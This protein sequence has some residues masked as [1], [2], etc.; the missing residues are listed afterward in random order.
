MTGPALWGR[1]LEAAAFP[2][3]VCT[4]LSLVA[5]TLAAAPS[6]ARPAAESLP[7]RM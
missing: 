2:M 1:H 6:Q 3:G 7:M 5:V 4:R